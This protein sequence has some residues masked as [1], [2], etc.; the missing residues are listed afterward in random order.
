[1]ANSVA[2][3]LEVRC[4]PWEENHQLPLNVNRMSPFNTHTHMSAERIKRIKIHSFR[5]FS[6][7]A[8]TLS[9]SS[10]SR[11]K[12]R[13]I[14]CIQLLPSRSVHHHC[15]NIFGMGVALALMQYIIVQE[16]NA[17]TF[18]KCTFVLLSEKSKATAMDIFFIASHDWQRF[19]KLGIRC[20]RFSQPHLPPPTRHHLLL[21]LFFSV[22]ATQPTS[23]RFSFIAA[24]APFDGV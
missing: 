13:Q 10:A 4:S 18:R 15:D 20:C 16:Q 5:L 8:G 7:T 11:R 17:D 19:F 1:M 24:T 3:P 9:S 23:V 12:C 14:N 22:Y 6:S 21:L 2:L